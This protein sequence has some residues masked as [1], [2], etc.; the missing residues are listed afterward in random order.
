MYQLYSSCR[1]I[2]FF[3]PNIW[4]MM[5]LGLLLSMFYTLENLPGYSSPDRKTGIVETPNCTEKLIKQAAT[6]VNQ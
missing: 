6:K 1:K 4:L 3:G 2:S 5:D